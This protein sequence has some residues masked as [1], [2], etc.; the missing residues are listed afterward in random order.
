MG[1]LLERYL[2]D[3]SSDSWPNINQ[4][5]YLRSGDAELDANARKA[6]LHIFY[7]GIFDL[8]ELMNFFYHGLKICHEDNTKVL[9]YTEEQEY[10]CVRYLSDIDERRTQKESIDRVQHRLF[11]SQPITVFTS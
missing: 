4:D 9:M 3:K 8:K 1:K 11:K 6:C 5:H 10:T 7:D 2:L